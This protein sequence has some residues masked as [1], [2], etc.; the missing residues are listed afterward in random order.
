MAAAHS[1]IS[2][3]D[4]VGLVLAMQRHTMMGSSLMGNVSNLCLFGRFKKLC[5]IDIMRVHGVTQDIVRR[6]VGTVW[7]SSNIKFQA[8]E[9]QREDPKGTEDEQSERNEESWKFT[10]GRKE[11]IEIVN[12]KIELLPVCRRGSVRE[13][14][15]KYLYFFTK[16]LTFALYTHC[17]SVFMMFWH[18]ENLPGRGETVHSQ[19]SQ[20]LETAKGPAEWPILGVPSSPPGPGPL[21]MPCTQEARFL[22][23]YHPGPGARQLGTIH[24]VQRPRKLLKPASPKCSFHPPCLSCGNPRKGRGLILPLFP[25]FCLLTTLEIPSWGS[26]WC[27]CLCLWGP[28]A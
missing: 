7:K 23:L 21:H 3:T 9:R 16:L 24:L 2:F 12:K 15:E 26:A 17:I 25:I 6:G 19:A 28:W 14:E 22:C 1:F 20:S 5:H 13:I 10:D 4:L 8:L 27:L 11:V 18:L